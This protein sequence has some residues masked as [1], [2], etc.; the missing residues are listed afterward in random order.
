MRCAIFLSLALL[1]PLLTAA[2]GDTPDTWRVYAGTY[3]GG[4]SEGIY[5]FTLDAATGEPGPVALAAG[6]EN[7]S[8]LAL[9]P[10][11]P[12]LYACGRTERGGM[13]SAFR[14]TDDR[15][16]LALLND[17]PSEGK[18]P[19]HVDVAPS[20]KHVAVANYS[21]GTMA[22][23][24]VDSEGAL[25][26][27]CATHTYTGSGPHP[28]RQ[29]APHAHAVNFGP[30]NTVLYVTD[31]GTDRVHRH[32]Y[33]AQAGT[34]EPAD[35]PAVH[36]AP[37]AGPRHLAIHPTGRFAYVVN[38]LDNTVTALARTESGGLEIIHTI[39]TLPGDFNA[40][41]TTAEILVHPSG[42]YLY[43]SN[44]GH[45]SI[46]AF[47]IAP[48]TGRLTAIGHTPTGGQTPRNFNIDPAGRFLLAANRNTDNIVVLR[49]DTDTGVLEPT[50]HE[51]SMPTPVC[52]L[53]TA[54]Q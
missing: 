38:E 8:F 40:E 43:A 35:P 53:F 13:V 26:P 4:E 32:H 6:T 21:D 48:Q 36:L 23:L 27:A 10:A 28:T 20:G 42:K 50:E 9:H 54:V 44:R 45:D 18:G 11:A 14:M 29:Q 33:D 46:A 49:V 17:A 24:P 16:A 22:M 2:A 52:V 7:P 47:A 39:G 25:A 1:I 3:T 31:L 41:N 51:V 15:G 19:C 34:L 5:T 12:V 37:G 30:E